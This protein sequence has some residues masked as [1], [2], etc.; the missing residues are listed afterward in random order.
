MKQQR[1]STALQAV[2]TSARRFRGDE[3]GAMAFFMLFLFLLMLMIGGIAI[4]VMRFE[5]RR[6]AMQQTM[7][8]AA[9]A[10]ASLTQTRTPS[11][12]ANDWFAKASLGTG[13]DMVSFSAP[14]VT[15]TADAGLR[16]VKLSSSVRSENFF[17]T[18]LSDLE[19]LEGP[20]NTE[21]AQGVSDIEVLLVLDITG[22][23]SQL[24]VAGETKTKIQALREAASQFVTIVKT[25]DTKNGVS[26]GMVPYASQVNIPANLRAR[27]NV[28]KLST[29][30]G[31]ANAGVPFINCIEIP[32]STYTSTALSTTT[33]MNMAAV[34]DFTGVTTTTDYR[35]VTSD[36]VSSQFGASVCGTTPNVVPATG[37][38][39]RNEA[40][41]N[42][43]LLPT[44]DGAKVIT[45]IGNLTANGNTSIAIGMRWGSALIDQSAR[46]IYT[47]L[48][49]TTVQGRPADN[50]SVK[51]RKIII[52]MTDG[53]NVSANHIKDAYKTGLSPIY[54]GADGKFAIRFWS[55]STEA[56]NKGT[57]PHADAGV[58]YC[59][60]WQLASNREY[61]I[62][63]LK[64]NK[65]KA[66]V[67]N[68][69]EGAGTGTETA[70][71]CDPLAWK[72]TPSWTGSGTV[73]QLDWSEVWR[74]MRVEYLAEQLY[75]RSN[76]NGTSNV[77]GTFRQTY[78]SVSNL[79]T[80]LSQNCTAAKNAGI[81][82]YGI[83]FAA[84][85]NGQTQISNCSSDPK[86]NYY[87]DAKDNGKLTAAFNQIATDIS[88]LR[89]TQ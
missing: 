12:I 37:P 15:S 72:T 4:D 69:A 59:S 51:T 68:Q 81:E 56:L 40:T 9:L 5:T 62:P 36:P 86:V 32:A 27:F 26:I 75:A 2:M 77:I 48:A 83:A 28:A 18:L 50:S 34:A 66:K 3:R 88:E 65:V 23:M 24:A 46:P 52:L 1:L 11:A 78:I 80:Y 42:H 31:V 63:H 25:N 71:G 47:A 73:T 13:L 87:Y 74:Y 41:D 76:V 19:Y 60:G 7:D 57:R 54:R 16:R 10:A 45:A 64:A 17:M 70:G 20:T 43:V 89:L 53:E 29:W 30:D 67:G 49:D 21:A 44:K 58:N 8:R 33:V 39:P 61:F 55:S 22:S 14:V 79:N 82:I 84:P 38:D 85:A 35:A 6:V